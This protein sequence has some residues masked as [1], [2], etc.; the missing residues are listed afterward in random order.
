MN[1]T[2]GEFRLDDPPQDGITTVEFGN[3]IYNLLVSSWDCTV[4]L[5]DIKTNLLRSTYKN[6]SSVLDCCY[7]VSKKKFRYIAFNNTLISGNNPR[8]SSRY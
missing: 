7:Y 8:C 5:Y 2:S 4:R 3:S 1:E 6:N